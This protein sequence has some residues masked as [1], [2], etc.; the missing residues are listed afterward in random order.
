MPAHW[1]ACPVYAKAILAEAAG[2]SESVCCAESASF[3]SPASSSF[4]SPNTN[5]AR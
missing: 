4:T 3:F 1:P 2:S 5:P